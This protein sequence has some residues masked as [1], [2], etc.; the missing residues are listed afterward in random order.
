M[1]V[2]PVAGHLLRV[3]PVKRLEVGLDV[4][5]EHPRRRAIVEPMH[6]ADL[7]LDVPQAERGQVELVGDGHAANHRVI[8]VADVESGVEVGDGGRTSADIAPRFE[9]EGV[10]AGPGQV[11]G[12]DQA[13]VARADDDDLGLH[14]ADARPGG[15]GQPRPARSSRTCRSTLAPASTSSGAVYSAM[16]WLR[17]STLGVKIM[18][19]GHTRASI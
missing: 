10:D 8:A 4:V 3:R 9:Q 19:L 11:R 14:R 13:V 16:L 17:P 7:R 2:L 12:A 1:E 6:G 18:A 15:P 5:Q